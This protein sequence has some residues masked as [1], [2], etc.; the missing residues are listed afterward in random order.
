MPK[1]RAFQMT[2]EAA[3]DA[4]NVALGTFRVNVFPT[5]IL[6]DSGAN[7]SFMSHKFGGRLA[8]LVDKL[9]NALVV[10]VV[11][12]KFISISDCIKTIFINL[13][14][15]KFHDELLPIEFNGFDIVLE[16]D[17][18][19][20]NNVEILCKKKMVRVNPPGKEPFM[21]YGDKHRV[22]FGIISLMKAR[23][24]LSKECTSYLAS[25]IDANKDKK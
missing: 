24:Y 17:W 4:T 19:S 9:D 6:F 16:M 2:L 10:K 18:L 13:N 14:G 12:G 20:A 1:A 23:K 22:K 7:Y 25:M 5:N 15:N 21:V 8:L 3:N 11:S